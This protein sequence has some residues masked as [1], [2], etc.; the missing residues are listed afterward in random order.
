[1]ALLSELDDQYEPELPA[2]K[3][4]TYQQKCFIRDSWK[5]RSCQN[6]N[7]ITCHHVIYRSKGGSNKLS[8]LLTLCISC[9]DA[10]H[11]H[12]LIVNVVELTEDN[13][14]VRFIRRKGWKPT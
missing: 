3:D 14:V 7:G 1:M 12:K 5:C 9:H 11:L 10:V 2:E 8:N 4:L 6:R 13:L